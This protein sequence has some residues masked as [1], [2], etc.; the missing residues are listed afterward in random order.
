MRI[1]VAGASGVIGRALVPLL[2]ARGDDVTGMTRSAEKASLLESL[3]A[4]PVVCDV[5]DR[6]AVV[7]AVAAA[8]PEVVVHELTDLPDVFDDAALAANERIR[9][10][11]TANLV[12]AALAAGARRMLAQS[13]AFPTGPATAELERLTTQTP[14]LEGVVLRY[15]YFY[16]PGTYHPGA[17]ADGDLPPEPRVSIRRAAEQ[18]VEALDWEPGIYEIVDAA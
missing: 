3:G 12:E 17:P 16:G 2:V 1:F 5:Y 7:A 15:G 4:A 14:R 11:G 10:E 18:T 9:R 8:R 6:D 13:T